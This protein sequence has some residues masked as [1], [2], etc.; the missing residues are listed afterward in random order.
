MSFCTLKHLALRYLS[1]FK[2][3]LPVVWCREPSLIQ[4]QEP[5][6]LVGGLANMSHGV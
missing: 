1:V 5:L 4:L 2:G 3:A 6:L